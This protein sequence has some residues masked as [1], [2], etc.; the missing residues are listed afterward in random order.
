MVRVLRLTGVF[1]LA[2]APL[3]AR[4]SC[5]PRSRRQDADGG[6]QDRDDGRAEDR[7]R[8]ERSAAVDLC[9]RDSDGTR[10]SDGRAHEG[11]AQGHQRLGVRPDDDQRRQDASRA[12]STRCAWTRAGRTGPRRTWA[13]RSPSVSGTGVA[14]ML[15]GDRGVSNTDPYAEKETADN[16]WV[17]SPR[18]HHDAL[19]GSEERSTRTRT[20]RN[21]GGPWVMWKGTP[22]AHLMV[23]DR[24]SRRAR[25]D[26]PTAEVA[27]DEADAVAAASASR[28]SLQH[29]QAFDTHKHL[30]SAI[31]V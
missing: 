6:R 27:V 17:V 16:R 13:H 20:T 14:Y 28:L 25:H 18:A 12:S 22:Y 21:N 29:S 7:K 5:R 3:S 23:P 19:L 15:K 30:T 1:L 2:A 10:W 8:G 4:A 9:P 26:E 24:V 31:R 11:T